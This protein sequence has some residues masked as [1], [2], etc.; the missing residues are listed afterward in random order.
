[1]S[2]KRTTM[3]DVAKAAGVSRTTVSFVLNNIPNSNIADATRERVLQV[4][5]EL[6]YAPNT[7]ALNLVTGRTMMIALVVR[8]TTHQMAS[9]AFLGAV[10]EGIMQAIEPH[11]YHLMIHAAQPDG[12]NS[13]YRDLIRT[14][15]ADG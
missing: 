13:T 2:K 4:A 8:K 10:I 11:G 1:M 14:R 6:D 9:D 12:V 3:E 5:R 15:K 7:Q